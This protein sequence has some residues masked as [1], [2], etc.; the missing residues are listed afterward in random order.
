MGQVQ[1]TPS[2]LEL[3][4][5]IEDNA[6]AVAPQVQAHNVEVRT[7]LSVYR[8]RTMSFARPILV[9]VSCFV[10]QLTCTFR[11]RGLVHKT[12]I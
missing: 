10:P 3:L 9:D 8:L 5:K 7:V 2:A 11:L 12:A 1:G 6:K 4:K